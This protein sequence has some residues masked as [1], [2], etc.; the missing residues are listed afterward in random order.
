MADETP[1][2]P[3]R[4]AERAPAPVEMVTEVCDKV[5]P[6][7]A[8]AP[9]CAFV[10]DASSSMQLISSTLLRIAG[11][12]VESFGSPAAAVQRSIDR[13]PDLMVVRPRRPGIEAL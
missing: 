8:T 7:Q 9:R 4:P 13:C 6:D 10:V 11:F 5:H 3:S 2:E 1:A 12:S